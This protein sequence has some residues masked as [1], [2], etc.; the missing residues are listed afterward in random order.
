MSTTLADL[1]KLVEGR[2]CGEPTLLITGTGTL[3]TVTA[4]Q[5]TLADSPDFQ[6]QLTESAAYAAVVSPEVVS[7]EKPTIV[8]DDVHAAFAKIVTHFLPLR[9]QTRI[10]ISNQAVVSSSAQIAEDV[11]IHPLAYVGDD[12]VVGAGSTIHAGARIMAGCILG[13]QVTVF[14]NGV[15]YENTQIGDRSILHAGAV[16]GA[17]GF[18]YTQGADGH[19]LSAQLG[20]VK[21]GADVEIGA[22]ATVDRGTYG[23]TVI[24]DGSKIDNLVQV[25]HNCRLGGKNLIC[26]QVG[27]AGSATT[28]DHVVMAGQVGVR[29]HVHVGSG[30]VLCSKSG[31]SNNIEDGEIVLG[32]PA[33]PVRKQKLQM[34]AISKLPEMRKEFRKLQRQMETMLEQLPVKDKSKPCDHKPGEQAA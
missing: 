33:T 5:I 1:A 11:D 14:P 6:V 29:D 15:L 2:L 3:S 18:G 26:S 10:G 31:I 23:P 4:G 24:G 22:C 34:V 17:Y 12:V 27:I 28:G 25:A 13:S 21:L 19:V 16:I 32:Q 7:A 8:V 30:A 9:N 20:Y